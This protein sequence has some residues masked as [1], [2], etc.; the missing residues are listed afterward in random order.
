VGELLA[1]L[2]PAIGVLVVLV[3]ERVSAGA[4]AAQY[5]VERDAAQV[6]ADRLRCELVHLARDLA[7]IRASACRCHADDVVVLVDA[8]DRRIDA[9]MTTR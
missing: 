1:I 4:R 9:A 8:C 3:I 6:Q 2:V 7:T 5:R